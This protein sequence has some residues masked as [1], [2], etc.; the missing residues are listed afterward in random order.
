M[1][2]VIYY[3]IYSIALVSAMGCIAIGS[4]LLYQL[5]IVNIFRLGRFVFYSVF[6]PEVLEEEWKKT[7]EYMMEVM[8][9]KLRER[10]R[11]EMDIPYAKEKEK[12]CLG[13]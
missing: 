1:S 4:W 6:F 13:H 9:N 8:N 11:N 7:P 12:Y 2:T 5:I 10:V 3:T